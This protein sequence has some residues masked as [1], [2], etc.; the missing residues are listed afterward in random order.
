MDLKSGSSKVGSRD[1]GQDSDDAWILNLES[2]IIKFRMNSGLESREEE[3][4][5]RSRV[6]YR[7]VSVQ[8]LLLTML[9]AIWDLLCLGV[10]I[11]SFKDVQNSK[12]VHPFAIHDVENKA[13]SDRLIVVETADD[14]R[15]ETK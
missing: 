1:V 7:P 5:R 14:H 8:V 13:G 3:T 9:C 6:T 10:M 2:T 11:H 12:V 4:T 15:I